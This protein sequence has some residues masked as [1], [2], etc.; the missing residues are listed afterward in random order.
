MQNA[1]IICI[2]TFTYIQ[3]NDLRGGGKSSFYF[4]TLDMIFACLVYQANKE[5]GDISNTTNIFCKYSRLC[6]NLNTLTVLEMMYLADDKKSQW[7]TL[8]SREIG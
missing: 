1:F 4:R 5:R 6:F 3:Y 8:V 7:N 2:F